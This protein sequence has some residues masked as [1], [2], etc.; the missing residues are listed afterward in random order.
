VL[1]YAHAGT[2]PQTC[3]L[4]RTSCCGIDRT[5][6]PNSGATVRGVS[7]RA[8]IADDGVVL[9]RDSGRDVL[10][11]DAAATD[12]ARVSRPAPADV[13]FDPGPGAPGSLASRP[14]PDVDMGAS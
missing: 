8:A 1:A 7:R 14:S 9:T 10:S 13:F 4:H 6:A 12:A 2:R 11:Y 3:A 5:P